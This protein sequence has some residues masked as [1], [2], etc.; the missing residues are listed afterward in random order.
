MSDF[1]SIT[2]NSRL[3]SDLRQGLWHCTSPSE[4]RQIL[5]DGSIKPNDGRV[6]HWRGHPY[7]CQQLGAV[8]LFDFQTPTEQEVLETADLWGPFIC[9]F[10]HRTTVVVGLSRRE[11][12]PKLL[13]YPEN[14]VHT[15]GN[16]IPYVET[17]HCGPIPITVITKCLLICSVDCT[18]FYVENALADPRLGLVERE[19]ES[20]TS[21]HDELKA[22]MQQK[23]AANRVSPELQA[24]MQKARQ[25]AKE[26][27]RRFG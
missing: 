12:E 27:T 2:T 4:Y 16:V 18:R 25:V 1:M 6:K 15:T 22:T 13:P 17:C 8:S 14:K 19:F 10:A 9:N 20:A 23:I 21:P 5:R 24:R 11:L 7:A 3:F 26:Y